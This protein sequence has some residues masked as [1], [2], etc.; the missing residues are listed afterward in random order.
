MRAE[1][2]A[3]TY[4]VFP[5]GYGSLKRDPHHFDAVIESGDAKARCIGTVATGG[6]GG[7]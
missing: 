2:L 1:G 3:A 6:S 5:G 4:C 7:R